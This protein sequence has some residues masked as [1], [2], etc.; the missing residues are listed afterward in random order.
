M[1]RGNFRNFK[2]MLL[3][4]T[5]NQLPTLCKKNKKKSPN[6]LRIHKVPTLQY[7][8][9]QYLVPQYLLCGKRITIPPSNQY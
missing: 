2:T 7:N 3:W 5:K 4:S 9:I 1:Y 8:I 6:I